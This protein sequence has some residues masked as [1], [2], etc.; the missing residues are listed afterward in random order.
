MFHR[1]GLALVAACATL[2]FAGLVKAA[3]G[4]SSTDSQVT[5]QQPVLLDDTTTAPATPATAAP[6]PPPR[7]LTAALNATPLGTPMGNANISITGFVEGSTTFIDHTAP[8]VAGNGNNIFGRSFDTEADSLLLD[9]LDL[10]IAKSVDDTQK[11]FDV[12]FTVEQMYGA[13]MAYIHSNGLTTY[14]PSKIDGAYTSSGT[15]QPKDQYDLTQANLTFAVPVGNGML[16]TFGKFVTPLGA[17]VIDAPGNALYSHSFLFGQIPF[18]QTGVTVAYNVTSELTATLGTTRGWDQALKDTNGDMDILASFAYTSDDKKWT[19]ALNISSGN[20]SADSS[21]TDGWRTV[22]D[23]VGS[24]QYS[25]N[26]KLTLNADY[27]WQKQGVVGGGNSQWYGIAA[28]AAYT[29]CDYVTVNGRAEWFNDPNGASPG[30]YDPGVA[31][32]YYEATL[33]VAI[34]PIPHNNIGKNLVFRPEVRDDYANSAAWGDPTA[35]THNQATLALEGY[36]T[37]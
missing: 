25:D 4:G 1:K 27:G 24:Y 20:E 2:A 11:K 35:K 33:G 26:L 16:V 10:D 13:D 5:A 23:Y 34:T 36:F 30:T 21:G 22:L 18:T 28:Y 3:D 14:S 9:Q 19:H 17:E 8:S 29:V 7:P 32:T 37:F 31:N 15:R 6:T 12:G